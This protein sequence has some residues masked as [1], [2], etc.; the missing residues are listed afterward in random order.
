MT[1]RTCLRSGRQYYRYRGRHGVDPEYPLPLDY[2][3]G[4]RRPVN[5]VFKYDDITYFFS[6]TG[7]QVFDD[8]NF[9]V[10]LASFYRATSYASCRNSVCPSVCLSHTCFV[11]KENNA[12]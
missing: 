4:V 7:Y 5:D 2:W 1:H 12:L 3:K 6:G 8:S 10:S 11:T 9:R